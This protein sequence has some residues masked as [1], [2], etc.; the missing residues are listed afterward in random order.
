MRTLPEF[1]LAFSVGNGLLLN[2]LN[3]PPNVLIRETLPTLQL[4]RQAD[5]LIFQGGGNIA[6]EAIMANTRLL[7]CPAVGDQ[8]GLSARLAYHGMSPRL[9][10]A[11]VRAS[12]LRQ[13]ILATLADGEMERRVRNMGELFRAAN[14]DTGPL[15]EAVRRLTAA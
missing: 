7:T 6:K 10:L 13:L 9:S 11:R 2:R 12:T 5:L 1:A 14:D 15:N 4:L 3:V 8:P